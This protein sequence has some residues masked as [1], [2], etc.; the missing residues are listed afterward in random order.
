MGSGSLGQAGLLKMEQHTLQSVVAGDGQP[1]E[2]QLWH[3]KL[4][5]LEVAERTLA[6]KRGSSLSKHAVPYQDAPKCCFCGCSLL[7]QKPL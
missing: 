3:L 2:Q 4:L 1:V 5:A 6:G 7:L